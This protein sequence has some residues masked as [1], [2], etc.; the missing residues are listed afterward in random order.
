VSGHYILEVVVVLYETLHDLNRK[1]LNG[2]LFK[3][4]FEKT[5]DK[6]NWPFVQQVLR[7]K[8]LTLNGVNGQIALCKVGQ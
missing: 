1:K 2:V 8:G 4:D 5:Y 7:M 3:I 6:V